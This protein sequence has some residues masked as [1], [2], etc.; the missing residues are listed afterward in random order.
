MK[1]AVT[2]FHIDQV[3]ILLQQGAD[4]II[5]GNGTYAN[6]LVCS[7]SNEELTE[8]ASLVH[9]KNKELYVPVNQMVHNEH[10][11]A[12]GSYLDTLSEIQVDG[13]VFGDVSIYQLAKEK[14]LTSKLIYNPETLNTNTFDPVFWSNQGIKGITVAK[15]I[16]LLDILAICD[17]STIEVSMIGHGHLNMF[18]SRRPLV[19]NF[20]KYKDEEYDEYINNRKLRL[21]EEVRNESYP[22]FQDEHGTHIFREKPMQA[23]EEILQLRSHL[24]VFIIDGILMTDSEIESIV[25]AYHKILTTNDL[26]LAKEIHNQYETT[27][28]SGFLYKKTVYVKE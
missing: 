9:N 13:I 22:I 15:E 10:L 21:V 6:R 20:F 19:E 24:D 18:H 2:L 17:Q 26:E 25:G 28:D 8:I 12:L 5:A 3:D 7:F 14:N 23:F 1:L 16:P 4:I 11:E 27:H